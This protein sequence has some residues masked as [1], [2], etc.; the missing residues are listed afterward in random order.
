MAKKYAF[1]FNIETR[2]SISSSGTPNYIVNGYASVPNH[3]YSYK[4][5]PNGTSFK[6]MFTEEGIKNLVRKAKSQNIFVDALHE[7][8]TLQNTKN[9]LKDI[10]MRSGIDI[11]KEATSILDQIKVS[12]IPIAKLDSIEVDDK[13]IKVETKLNPI[14]RE[15]D[16]SH[17]RYFDAIW[18]SLQDGFLN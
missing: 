10:Q 12:D 13:G 7:I 15:V 18:H 16:E 8:G 2:S 5:F 6:E 14:Y 11:S 17:R 3:A 9:L 4:Y 1:D